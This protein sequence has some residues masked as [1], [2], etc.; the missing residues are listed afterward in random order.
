M[1]TTTTDCEACKALGGGMC[2]YHQEQDWIANA[3]PDTDETGTSIDDAEYD[4]FIVYT[5]DEMRAAIKPMDDGTF[6]LRWTDMVLG[7]WSERYAKRSA[8]YLRLALL[9]ECEDR[10]W[11]YGFAEKPDEFASSAA[12]FVERGLTA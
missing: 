10:H 5:S 1:N 11:E 8:A 3:E 7:E 9:I 2:D 6:E 12:T 4:D